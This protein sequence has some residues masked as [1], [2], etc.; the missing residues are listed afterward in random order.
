LDDRPPPQA[1]ASADCVGTRRIT[2]N[3]GAA[4]ATSS[5]EADGGVW[6]NFNDASDA[7]GRGW[8]PLG[9]AAADHDRQHDRT[10]LNNYQVHG[11]ARC[12]PPSIS[13]ARK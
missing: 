1:P 6:W 5:V 8:I 11:L 12:E 7:A 3:A 10:V 4:N 9:M 13:A 2:G